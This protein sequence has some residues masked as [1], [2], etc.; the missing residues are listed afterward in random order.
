MCSIFTKYYIDRSPELFMLCNLKDIMQLLLPFLLNLYFYLLLISRPISITISCS[1]SLYVSLP[2]Y[3]NSQLSL[4]HPLSCI[5][6]LKFICNVQTIWSSLVKS[7]DLLYGASAVKLF[8][9]NELK[10][11]LCGCL[12]T[13]NKPDRNA[14][15]REGK[16]R[17]LSNDGQ[18]RNM[19]QAAQV[20]QVLL[21]RLVRSAI[22]TAYG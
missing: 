1:L 6:C 4:M 2:I 5:N 19:Q 12:K 13:A 20:A 8:A 22:F 10:C 17:K 18:R 11:D 21:F 16:T 9:V 3:I 15:R 7:F 14:R